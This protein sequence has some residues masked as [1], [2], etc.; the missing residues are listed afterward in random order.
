[1]N[2]QSF[3][4]DF[5]LP[6]ATLFV[7]WLGS[8]YRTRQKKEKDT[9]DNIQQILDIQKAYIADQQTELRGMRSHNRKLSEKL[10]HKDKSIRQANKCKY[11]NEGE[12]CPVLRAEEIHDEHCAT[13]HLNGSNIKPQQGND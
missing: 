10:E 1:M 11:T 9:L 6:I 12:G 5:I 13:C 2:L 4:V 7:G 3:L 8:A